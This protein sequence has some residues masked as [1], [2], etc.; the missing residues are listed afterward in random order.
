[1]SG[2]APDYWCNV[3]GDYLGHYFCGYLG[4][5]RGGARWRQ[6]RM[7]DLHVSNRDLSRSCVPNSGLRSEKVFLKGAGHQRRLCLVQPQLQQ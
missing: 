7:R 2:Y 4:G 1:M 6:R 5:R 3:G